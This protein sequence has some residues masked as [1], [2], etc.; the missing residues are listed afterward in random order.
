[1]KR[2]DPASG[3]S[4]TS[5][6]PGAESLSF[7]SVGERWHSESAANLNALT[8]DVEDYFQVSAF[9]QAISRDDWPGMECR[10]PQNVDR[11]LRLYEDADVSGTFFV[12]GWVAVHY[13]EVVRR[14]ADAGHEVASHGMVH[15]RVGDQTPEEFFA[16]IDRARKLLEDTGGHEVRGF[17]AAS[18]SLDQRTPWAHELI[19]EAGYSYSSSIY[20][21]VHDHY[22]VPNAPPYPFY[23][24]KSGILEIPAST[25][26]FLGRNWPAGGGGYFRLLP[27]AISRMLLRRVS[28]VGGIPAVFYYHPWELDPDQPRMSGLSLKTRFRH[29]VNI[30]RSEP[31]LKKLLQE[32]RW[33]R[34][35]R[36]Y[37]TSA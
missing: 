12:L 30:S 36:I 10:I 32:F 8:C 33:G 22:G 13:P 1:M 11:I 20:P 16:D 27:L 19:A 7:L 18:W 4:A 5:K 21:V 17:R 9:E 25:T 28:R 29:Y 15:S 6:G 34:M 3:P 31:R 35:D 26:R 24:E 14:I 37:L 23:V 2:P